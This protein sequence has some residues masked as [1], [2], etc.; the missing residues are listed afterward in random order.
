M[1]TLKLE[2]G[3]VLCPASGRD[4]RAD[5][6]IRDGRVQAVGAG[7]G[8][9]DEHLD[10][11][12]AVVCPA[13]VDL[14]AELG[15]PGITWRETLET[16]SRA[17]AAG[18]FTAVLAS[19]AT[20]PTVDDAAI[21]RE[22][23]SRAK[24]EACIEVLVAG[25]LTQGLRG[26]ELAELGLMAE[27]GAVAFS[28]GDRLVPDSLVLRNALLYARPFGLPVL[29]RAGEEALE[30]VASMHEGPAS[31]LAGL[32]GL[33]AAAEELAVARLISM[34][35]YT[36]AHIHI[37]GITAALA[38]A[39]LRRARQEGVPITGTTIALHTLL[40][41]QAVLDSCYDSNT[42]LL[43]PLREESDR[44]AVLDA[45]RDGT[46]LGASS[47][48]RPRTLVDKELEFSHARPGAVGLETALACVL[49]GSGDLSV[50]IRALSTGPARLLG[51]DRRVA[52]GA[53]AEL[54][55]V[56]GEGTWT[57]DPVR[58]HS[59]CRNTPLTGRSLPGRV[60][61]TLHQGRVVH[62]VL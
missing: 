29:L 19:P 4:E 60:R 49:A 44:R 32:R 59:K 47:G 38:V 18:G 27:A 55:V 11:S 53:P 33:P 6:L 1:S 37:L 57:V 12:G 30:S 35:R 25:G 42:R 62:S 34:A 14:D 54:A 7:L 22:L 50:A 16:G 13:L 52:E 10:C 31:L 28:N 5:V 45:L 48:H 51:L 58:F 3:R 36:G 26:E 20:D 41:D 56:E 17:A 21:V 39:W 23:A 46:L 9:A 8:P 24:D 40:T 15:D 43:P 61:H 2:G